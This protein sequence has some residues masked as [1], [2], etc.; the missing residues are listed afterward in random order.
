MYTKIKYSPLDMAKWTRN[1][2]IV[3]FILSLI[4]VVL[5]EVFDL[6]WLH[7]PWL[8]IALVGT[9]VAFVVSFQ[10]NAAYD[11]IWEARKIWGGIVNTSRSWAILVNDYITND[12][13]DEK[14][15]EEEIKLIK[16]ELIFRHIAWMTA[17]R[18]AMRAHKPWEHFL[19]RKSNREWHKMAKIREFD[20]TLEEELKPYVSDNDFN[21]ILS[22]TN[23]STHAISL[24]SKQLKA[25]R[26]KG[27]IEDFRH[28]EMQ[29]V[30]V[31]LYNLQGKS[32]RIKNFPYPRQFAT[33]NFYFVWIFLLMVPF[34]VMHE[35]DIIGSKLVENYPIIGKH[36]VWL[37]IPF[38]II[39]L[40]VF[41]TMERIGRTGDN[42]FEGTA[43]DVPITTIARGIEIDLREMI[44]ESP[45]SIPKPIEPTWGIEM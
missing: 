10:N 32:E 20:F 33:L 38:S 14:V 43:N 1:D 2:T 21:Y 30:L 36:F 29:N 27:L 17:L 13:A 19:K 28:M 12:F 25:L 35:F 6:K 40:W 15:S 34:G 26:K 45:E 9:A 31:E 16:K 23:K 24:Q 4:P 42:P 39:V 7:L 3:F 18:H 8:P 41:H 11:R 37:S 44:D 22:K 5:Y